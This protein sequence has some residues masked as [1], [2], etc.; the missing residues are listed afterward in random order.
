MEF[1]CSVIQDLLPLYLDGHCHKRS[2]TLVK[3]HLDTC[4]DCR[5]LY[6]D[7]VDSDIIEAVVYDEEK[8]TKKLSVVTK[9]VR[10]FKTALSLLFGVLLVLFALPACHVLYYIVADLLNRILK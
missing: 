9:K 8:E 4:D 10:L 3:N 7:Y 2:Y 1:N 5:N 6:R